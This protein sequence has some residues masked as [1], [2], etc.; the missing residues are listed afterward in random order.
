MASSELHF[1]GLLEVGRQIQ[2][3]ERSSVEV[4]QALLAR[5]KAVD[6]LLRSYARDMESQ[7]MADAQRA[8]QEISSRHVRGPLHGVPLAVKDLLW[9][10]GTPSCHGMTIH[11]DFRP[12]EDATS[13]R[14][15]REAGAVIL[16]KF[17][18]TEGAF[19]DHHPQIAPPVNPWGDA[20][21]PGVSSSGA[22]VA[23]AAG[24]CFGALGT[25][26]GGSIRFPSAAN[27]VTGIKP[28]WGRVSRHGA[29]ELAASMDHIGPIARSAADAGAILAAIA[30]PDPLDPTA[31][32]ASVPDYLATMTRGLQGLRI[33]IDRAWTIDRV[34]SPTKVVLL[35]ALRIAEDLGA[36]VREVTF[37]HATQAILDWAP[38]CAVEAAVAHDATFPS[39]RDEYG[40]W[41]AGLLDIGRSLDG[42]DYQKMLL[43]RA[44]FSGRVRTLFQSVDLLLVP[45][46]AFAAVTNER[47][48]TFA[49]DADLFAGMLQ[50]TCPFDLTGSPTI[51]LP[52]G[53]T[54]EGAPVAFQFVAPHFAEHLL[55]QAGWAY[56][57]STTWHQRHPEI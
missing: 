32:H 41:L 8:D 10:S 3:R 29:F 53:Q 9:T 37:P 46:T 12:T 18:Q 19:S 51:T 30:G 47:M 26:T 48:A 52:G 25:D 5:I 55:V 36:S 42:M 20:L 24:L 38:M 35:E 27:G 56:Q 34:D 50:Y 22:G 7:A 21:W 45:A 54:P 23:T 11:K 1:L 15:L 16:G 44:D 40:P 57:H 6:P 14:R 13:V 43:H 17:Q 2:S 39:R 33:G 28:T 4:T 49:Q 31:S